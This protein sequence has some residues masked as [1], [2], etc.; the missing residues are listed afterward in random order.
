MA[1]VFRMV[2]R[3]AV[4][5]APM[6]IAHSF[7][8]GPTPANARPRFFARFLPPWGV[9]IAVCAVS[10]PDPA[11]CLGSYTSEV[12]VTVHAD[13]EA[14]VPP[15][16]ETQSSQGPFQ[17]SGAVSARGVLADGLAMASIPDEDGLEYGFHFLRCHFF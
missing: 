14:G 17:A 11:P 4:V 16:P 3:F 5:F 7:H 13:D 8:A 10:L 15:S 6:N 12:T 1:A 9:A 2:R